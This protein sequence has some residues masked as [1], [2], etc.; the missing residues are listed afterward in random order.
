[1]IS[2]V[3]SLSLAHSSSSG[4]WNLIIA[5][6]S[7]T[8]ESSEVWRLYALMRQDGGKL[9]SYN[10]VFA[11]QAC[12]RMK[13]VERLKSVHCEALRSG[14]DTGEHVAPALVKAYSELGFV[15]DA[16]TFCS[17][18]LPCQSIL[19]GLAMR[20]LLKNSREFEALFLFSEMNRMRETPPDP[21][22]AVHAAQALGNVAA[23]DHGG[24]A[25]HGLCLKNGVLA[26]NSRLQ[27]SV[28]DMYSK[29]GL[30][31]DAKKLFQEIE[32]KDTTAWS[33]MV[34]RLAQEGR[35]VDALKIFRR[36]LV[37]MAAPNEVTIA[38]ALL[39]CSH[40]GALLHG[41]SL[42]GFSIRRGIKVDVVVVT[43]LIDMYCKCGAI[44]SARK[45]FDRM[46]DRNIFTWSAIIGGFGFQGLCSEALELFDQLKKQN[47]KP[48]SVIFVSLISACSHCG[49]VE[50]ARRIFESMTIDFGIAP[51]EEHYSCMVDLLGRAGLLEEAAALIQSMAAPPGAAV[52][53][54]FLGGCR[55]HRRV[56]LAEMAAEQLYRLESEQSG[57]FLLLSEVYAATGMA[58]MAEYVMAGMRQKQLKKTIGVSSL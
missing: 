2:K 34:T 38:S 48:N 19:W 13:N 20:N 22:C 29:S 42:H 9:D 27:T 33:L 28:V 24:A 7:K 18:V 14:L 44:W 5:R 55:L 16:K 11:I 39:A 43:A 1:M 26:S 3:L 6:C 37:T 23:A 58:H 31:S 51:A 45:L 41:R 21:S 10:S 35:S 53:G 12:A 54:A 57:A 49:K 56:D 32:G 25:F 8:Q 40:A 50:E 47:L 36:M 4:S 30:L 17:R 15:D 52:W 46:P